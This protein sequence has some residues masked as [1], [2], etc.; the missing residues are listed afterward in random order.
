MSTKEIIEGIKQLPFNERLIVIEK[1]LKTLHESSG[2]EL[3]NAAK[4][5]LADYKTDKNLTAFTALDF[6]E[7]Y[8][9]R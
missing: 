6:E 1:A 7:F 2:T 5:L 9:T 8:E 3:E 4:V